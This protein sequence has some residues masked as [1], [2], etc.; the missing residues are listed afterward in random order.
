MQNIVHAGASAH[1]LHQ[2]INSHKH[3]L[4]RMLAYHKADEAGQGIW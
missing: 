3:M 1:N 4:R 2:Y